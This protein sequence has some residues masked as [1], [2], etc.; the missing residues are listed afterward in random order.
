MIAVLGA[1][2]QLGSAFVRAL[3]YSC[4]AVTREELDLADPEAIRPWVESEKPELVIN[5][6]AYTAVDAAETDAETARAVNALAVEALA[7]A[8]ARHGARL[9]T[10]STDYVFDGE[11]ETGYVESDLPNPLNV[12]GRTKLE[13][14]QLALKANPDGLVIRTSWLLSATH[15][16]FLTTML[17]QLGDEVS[18]VDDQRGR[19]TFVDDLV[20]A[21]LEAVDTDASGI[22]HL[23]N[24]GETTWFELAREIAVLAGLDPGLVRPISSS[25][26][27]RPAIRPANSVLDSERLDGLGID[28]LSPYR[29]ALKLATQA[30]SLRGGRKS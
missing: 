15:R 8:T 3:N 12:Y 7:A 21:T 6:A 28:E 30:Q 29:R 24:Q 1:N 27:A 20:I 26:L 25:E 16:N 23:T 9:V 4:H 10:F 13:G 17:A 18:V 19:P 2:G 14:E 11:K 5:C 22:L